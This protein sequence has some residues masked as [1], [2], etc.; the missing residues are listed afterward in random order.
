MS[1]LDNAIKK[2]MT[3]FWLGNGFALSHNVRKKGFEYFQIFSLIMFI[4]IP[5]YIIFYNNFHEN[6]ETGNIVTLRNSIICW[7]VGFS[8]YP[9]TF[10]FV[11]IIGYK[12]DEF[13]Q[14]LV[15]GSSLIGVP[16]SYLM[17]KYIKST[18]I[19]EKNE[20]IELNSTIKEEK[21]VEDHNRHFFTVNGL[22]F[23]DDEGNF[24]TTN[25]GRRIEYWRTEGDRYTYIFTDGPKSSRVF[26]YF[27]GT[28]RYVRYEENV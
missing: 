11:G 9:L 19:R 1:L 23:L 27:D 13:V 6:N 26:L 18:K 12:I 21:S 24:M 25:N 2:M 8:L 20:Q 3:G 4:F 15:I 14:F 10:I 28:G 5:A 17:A 22:T 7:I 16:A